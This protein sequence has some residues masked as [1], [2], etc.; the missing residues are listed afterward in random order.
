MYTYSCT[1][2]RFLLGDRVTCSTGWPQTCHMKPSTP[3]DPPSMCHHPWIP[4]PPVIQTKIHV[5]LK[6]TVVERA[7]MHCSDL[8]GAQ[9]GSTGATDF[10]GVTK[11][12]TL[13]MTAPMAW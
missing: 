7:G 3:P 5:R 1:Q 4:T 11:N 13:A 6:M 8:R 2:F 9:Q 10:E 12:T